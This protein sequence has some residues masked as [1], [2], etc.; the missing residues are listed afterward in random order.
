LAPRSRVGCWRPDLASVVGAPI[1][2]RLLAPRSRVG[3]WRPTA[4]S[5]V[6]AASVTGA[7]VGCWRPCR[8]LA[9][10]VGAALPQLFLR[11]HRSRAYLLVHCLELD[12]VRRPRVRGV[13]GQAALGP[14]GVVAEL[15]VRERVPPGEGGERPRAVPPVQGLVGTRPLRHRLLEKERPDLALVIHAQVERP[16][17]PSVDAAGEA[18]VNHD[19]H[20]RPLRVLPPVG[21]VLADVEQPQLV[22]AP[23]RGFL[24]DEDALDQAGEL[25]EGGLSCAKRARRRRV[26]GW[27]W[28]SGIYRLELRARRRRVSGWGWGSGSF[29]G[30][31]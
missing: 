14:L 26:S 11:S 25:G 5:A 21:G 2:R 13:G 22:P 3:C 16:R 4:A 29:V 31:G 6:G 15:G 18:V 28:D 23:L 10:V 17:E 27:G 12:L 7:R 9:S 8:L 30:W 24:R 19:V 1:S 20:E